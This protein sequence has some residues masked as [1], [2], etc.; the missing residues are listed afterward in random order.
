MEQ[1][2]QQT[3]SNIE[4]TPNASKVGGSVHERPATAL[5]GQSRPIV[6]SPTQ[7]T[8]PTVRPEPSRTA[9]QRPIVSAK[10]EQQRLAKVLDHQT[11]RPEQQA[12]K[13]VSSE[14]QSA[15]RAV[16][17]S[18][19]ERSFPVERQTQSGSSPAPVEKLVLRQ[20]T[21]KRRFT[22]KRE[23][24]KGSTITPTSRKEEPKS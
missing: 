18:Q 5:A 24:I 15:Q 17:S 14:R 3:A 13:Q 4:K 21:P 16:S 12:E 11:A 22:V 7:A 1:A 19:R 6:N 10:G 20:S 2:R 23:K 9:A 8:R